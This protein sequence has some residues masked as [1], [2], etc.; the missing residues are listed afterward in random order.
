MLP[1][2]LTNPIVLHRVVAPAG[3]SLLSNRQ[4]GSMGISNG[5]P[6][7]EKLMDDAENSVRPLGRLH[8]VTISTYAYVRAF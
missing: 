8:S 5:A 3:A 6:V 2:N 4:D 7:H 1:G